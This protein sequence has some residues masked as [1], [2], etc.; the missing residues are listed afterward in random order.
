MF[1]LLLRLF[2]RLL[3]GSCFASLSLVFLSIAVLLRLLPRFLRLLARGVRGLLVLSFR[4]YQSLLLRLDSGV[5]QY[6]GVEP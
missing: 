4:L 6:L 2:D 3:L 1:T 5:R